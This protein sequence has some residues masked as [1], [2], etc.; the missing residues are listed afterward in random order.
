MRRFMNILAVIE[1]GKP[2]G[3]ATDH[4][5]KLARRNDGEITIMETFEQLPEDVLLSLEGGSGRHIMKEFED[6]RRARLDEFA[7]TVPGCVRRT[8]CLPPVRSPRAIW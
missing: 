6:R 4:A 5:L 1:H 8:G 2:P 7:H 3:S